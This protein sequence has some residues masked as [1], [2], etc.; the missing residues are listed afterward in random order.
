MW[1]GWLVFFPADGAS[2]IAPPGPETTQSNMASLTDWAEVLSEVYLEG[3]LDRAIA[4]K[5]QPSLISELSRTERDM[6][7]DATRRS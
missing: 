2:P 7:E 1:D 4:L 6:V 3:A 5:E